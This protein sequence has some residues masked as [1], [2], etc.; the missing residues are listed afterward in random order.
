[1]RKKLVNSMEKE[2]IKAYFNI[3]SNEFYEGYYIK[4][5]R[6]NGFAMPCFEGDIANLFINNFSS[7]YFEIIYDKDSDCYICNTL[8]DGKI[9]QTDIAEKKIINTE[10]GKKEVYDF[11]LGWTWDDYKL[12]D[13]KNEKNISIITTDKTIEKDS[14]NLEY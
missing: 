4:E 13:L 5:Q 7:E 1:M 12:E 11:A 3:G 6:W 8:E 10:N 9:I 14:I 2:Y